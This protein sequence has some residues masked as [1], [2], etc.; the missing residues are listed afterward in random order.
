MVEDGILAMDPKC[1]LGY[2]AVGLIKVPNKF[3]EGRVE[4]LGALVGHIRSGLAP[5]SDHPFGDP[6]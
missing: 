6:S 2:G 5:P 4:I 3:E 1:R